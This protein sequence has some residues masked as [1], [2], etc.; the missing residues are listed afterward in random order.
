MDEQEQLGGGNGAMGRMDTI[1]YE[2]MKKKLKTGMGLTLD[3]AQHQVDLWQ[4]LHSSAKA[5]AKKEVAALAEQDDVPPP[6]LPPACEALLDELTS[7][8]VAAD[9]ALRSAVKTARNSP[10]VL[11]AYA[12]HL[13]VVRHNK[14][15][16]KAVQ[17]AIA[18]IV[19]DD[20]NYN[21][22]CGS[23]AGGGGGG[24]G[25]PSK[26][27]EASNVS[28]PALVDGL[29]AQEPLPPVACRDLKS[30]RLLQ[31]STVV[32]TVLLAAV[33]LVQL[34]A[35]S[36]LSAEFRETFISVSESGVRRFFAHSIAYR[37]RGMHRAAHAGD[38]VDFGTQAFMLQRWCD[39]MW[40][41]HGRLVNDFESTD[42]DVMQ[43]H[44]VPQF[45]MRFLDAAGDVD[46]VVLDGEELVSRFTAAATRV[47][48]ADPAS[49][50]AF[51]SS[52]AA[53]PD[54]FLVLENYRSVT[55]AVDQVTGL[56]Q[57]QVVKLRARIE[58]N[59]TLLASLA[60][61]VELILVLG[62]VR[63]T[64]QAVTRRHRKTQQR[65]AAEV[66]L[67]DL[68]HM[69]KD[70]VA[71]YNQVLASV[72]DED[73]ARGMGDDGDDDGASLG[74]FD[75][76]LPRKSSNLF[77][78]TP[79]AKLQ[80]LQ[81]EDNPLSSDDDDDDRAA[82]SA[83]ARQQR[84][85]LFASKSAPAPA[86]QV[87]VPTVTLLQ[88][89]RAS[90][91]ARRRLVVRIVYFAS[92]VVILASL[93][94]SSYFSVT[95]VLESSRSA[96]DLNNAN[97]L[98]SQSERAQLV[99][100]ELC[101]PAAVAPNTL[102]GSRLTDFNSTAALREQLRN[103]AQS[104]VMLHESMVS[105]SAAGL[106]LLPAARGWPTITADMPYSPFTDNPRVLAA[107]LDIQRSRRR[108][109]ELDD[110]MFRPTCLTALPFGAS[111]IVN[112]DARL[113]YFS[114][115]FGAEMCGF[116]QAGD[117][118]VSLGLHRLIEDMV[119]LYLT[120]ADQPEAVLRPDNPLLQQVSKYVDVSPEWVLGNGLPI[121]VF[122]EHSLRAVRN[123]VVV[124]TAAFAV[125][126]VTFVLQAVLLV[127]NARVLVAGNVAQHLL[128]QRL[129]HKANTARAAAQ[130]LT[131]AN[132]ATWGCR[133]PQDSPPLQAATGRTSVV[134]FV[135]GARGSGGRSPP[136]DSP[137]L[138]AVGAGGPRLGSGR[139]DSPPLCAVVATDAAV[140]P[141]AAA[142][143]GD[144]NEDR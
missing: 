4:I 75:A 84:R 81:S 125:C 22:G 129:V 94:I 87:V 42:E 80:A 138:C 25:S 20:D 39:G 112:T 26:R 105:G 100:K 95:T 57:L 98:L 60:A 83:T 13:L 32:G 66:S 111:A 8:D 43:W 34:L 64:L 91:V 110:V 65:L 88:R 137:P 73:D 62:I 19:G 17:Q 123:S 10:L 27:S 136:P 131:A 99:A 2:D 93:A 122:L 53:F 33:M 108:Y 54:L 6:V 30:S 55:Q 52:H 104:I 74:G 118:F 141:A 28:T 106:Q 68:A 3:A 82:G 41:M 5:Q 36:S 18:N 134:S 21:S 71:A 115:Q 127:V 130:R 132:T 107:S 11:Q 24:G 144:E 86:K 58:L 119:H 101:A 44:D 121:L 126:V 51:S 117:P 142:T 120:I 140:A 29:E 72:Q 70:A 50:V 96:A 128:V 49:F 79:R 92:L 90:K 12:N 76:T 23:S 63:P 102:R 139:P 61:L 143:S 45:S 9:A 46:T 103:S 89:S 77:V 56:Y 38:A 1:A 97:R 69:R 31:L 7:L 15:A 109:T 113:Q 37:A 78:A 116:F 59:S 48:H 67:M 135:V 124:Q 85:R 47:V 35:A 114:G 40:G 133:E 16:H 14:D